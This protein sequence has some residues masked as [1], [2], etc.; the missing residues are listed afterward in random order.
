MTFWHQFYRTFTNIILQGYRCSNIISDCFHWFRTSGFL[1]FQVFN[2]LPFSVTFVTIIQG[3]LV[4]RCHTLCIVLHHSD[5]TFTVRCVCVFLIPLVH[6]FR[7]FSVCISLFCIYY[8]LGLIMCSSFFG[9]IGH[10]KPLYKEI[11]NWSSLRWGKEVHTDS[12]Q[13]IH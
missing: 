2:I 12:E 8:Y 1:G 7:F 11:E 13:W 5:N 6:F 4:Y 9:L 10:Q 3:S